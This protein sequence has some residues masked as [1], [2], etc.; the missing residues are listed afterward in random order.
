LEDVKSQLKGTTL[1]VYWYLLKTGK[2]T[3]TRRVQRE[4][5][6]SSP[7]VAAYHLEKLMNMEVVKKNTMGDYELGKTISLEVM[8]SFVKISQ[9]M[10]P[11]YMFYS[12][13]FFTLLVVFV[14]GYAQILSIQGVYAVVF[15][16]S[17][18]IIMLYETWRHWRLR[19]I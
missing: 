19:P 14:V 15:G 18:V 3:T 4:L 5:G 9:L 13:F 7:S 8:G 16:G 10:I 1:K 12:I 17:G 2:P 6:L 11:R